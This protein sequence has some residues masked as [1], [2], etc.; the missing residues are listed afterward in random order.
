LICQNQSIICFI[1]KIAT[2]NNSVV[3]LAIGYI[4]IFVAVLS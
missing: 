2:F 1:D 3:F 4:N